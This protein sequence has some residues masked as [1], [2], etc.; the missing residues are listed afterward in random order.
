PDDGT[1]T[2][3]F[4][5]TEY[6]CELR[7][8]EQWR[9]IFHE[10]KELLIASM[11]HELERLPG[12]TW[13]FSQ[14]IEDNVGETVSGTKGQ[15]AVKLFGEDLHLLDQKGAEVVAAMT[16]VAGIKD[17]KLFRNVGQPNLNFTI[18]RLQA[19]RNGINVSD[20]Q[21]AIET[22]VG[23]K[24]V[25]EVLQGEQRYDVVV[26]YQER[27]RKTKEDI[28]RILLVNPVG[29]RLSLGQLTK[30]DVLD[31]A[32]DIYREGNTRYV[33][34]TFNV[35]GRDLGSTVEDAMARVKRLVKLPP[36][37]RLQWA[38]EYENQQR[39]SE[40]LL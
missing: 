33:A 19:A 13:N 29:Q 18:D 36:G 4:G 25:S 24:A 31:G 1:D 2:G 5:N 10:D 8:K 9:P 7:P 35:R 20:V 12:A 17:L 34:V 37:Y 22:A 26:R 16:G 38:G 39:S 28:A 40:R 21:D 27:F 3:G 32:Y 11:N 15:L 23:G 30:V 14:P 6:F